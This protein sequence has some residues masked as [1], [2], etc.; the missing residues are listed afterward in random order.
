MTDL[1]NDFQD[2][3]IRRQISI[4]R[5]SKSVQNKVI[6][7]LRSSDDKVFQELRILLEK[8]GG[9]DIIDKNILKR[10]DNFEKKIKELKKNSYQ[11]ILSYSKKEFKEFSGNETNRFLTN[12]SKISPVILELQDADKIRINAII[13][14]SPFE[15]RSFSSWIKKLQQ[16]DISKISSAIKL[17][18]V[19]GQN[20]QEILSIVKNQ[21]GGISRKH[22]NTITR[23]GIMNVASR[24][25]EEVMLLNSDVFQKEL[26]V[27]VLDGRTSFICMRLDGKKFD[28]GKGLKPPI[29]P[30][31]RSIR[32]PVFD[33]ARIGKRPIN[34]ITEKGLLREFTKKENIK[35]VKSRKDLPRGFKTQYDTFSRKRVRELIGRVPSKTNYQEFLSRQSKQFQNDT[36]GKTRAKLFRQG[37]ITVDNFT[38]K[39]G[40]LITIK[41]LK[42]L[43]N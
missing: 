17:G 1:N 43:Y 35:N 19:Q 4:L 5:Y 29:H 2:Y 31:C 15:G 25:R 21:V 3:L 33:D 40:D 7:I 8:V 36:L 42:E 6:D 39:K 37:K 20:N 16:D 12:L 30:N 24:V 22:L 11:E 23:T 27:S 32:V 38:D 10:L 18:L 13:N 28:V 9:K 26:H 41:E 34:P 14:S